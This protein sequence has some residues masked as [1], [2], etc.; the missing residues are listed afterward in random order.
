MTQE[1]YDKVI[2]L[3]MTAFLKN[4]QLLWRFTYGLERNPFSLDDIITVSSHPAS[5]FLYTS[6]VDG[7]FSYSVRLLDGLYFYPKMHVLP[8]HGVNRPASQED[9]SAL[10]FLRL[11]MQELS[12]LKE[13]QTAYEKGLQEFPMQGMYKDAIQ[14]G[15][16]QLKK[17]SNYSL[18]CL[19]V[20][21]QELE[22]LSDYFYDASALN[23]PHIGLCVRGKTSASLFN[24]KIFTRKKAGENISVT[25]WKFDKSGREVPETRE[26][27]QRLVSTWHKWMAENLHVLFQNNQIVEGD[28]TP[29]HTFY[30][31]FYGQ[32]GFTLEGLL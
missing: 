26:D 27:R 9:P 7:G 11:H 5:L 25:S 3:E 10:V 1:L 20:P 21:R 28:K 24:H 2:R 16:A 4:H 18:Y 14:K 32:I 6:S 17:L 19:S 8:N 31:R 22:A 29:S 12:K 13:N 23:L 15:Q 30:Q